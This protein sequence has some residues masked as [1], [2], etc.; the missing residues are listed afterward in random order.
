LRVSVAGRAAHSGY[1][2]LGRSAIEPA[3]RVVTALAGL[4]EA[5]EAERVEASASFPEVPFVSLNVGTIRGGAAP[6]VVPDRCIADLALRPLPGVATAPLIERVREAVAAAAGT[7][8]WD[9]EVVSESPPMLTPPES[10]LL[11]ALSEEA[12]R[13]VP[14]TVAYATDAGWLQTLGMDCAIFG[15]GDIATSRHRDGTPAQRVRAGGRSRA[16]PVGA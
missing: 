4:L 8:P 9:L 1:P 2:H 10:P 13:A 3:A 14:T 12:G 5:L 7:T 16:G 6:N 15:P 11:R